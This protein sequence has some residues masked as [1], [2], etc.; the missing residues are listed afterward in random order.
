MNSTVWCTLTAPVQ[1]WWNII[2][3]VSVVNFHTS[4]AYVKMCANFPQKI[5]EKAEVCSFNYRSGEDPLFYMKRTA[6]LYCTLSYSWIA[7]YMLPLPIWMM[8]FQNMYKSSIEERRLK[9]QC[10]EIFWHFFISWIE[11]IW[12]PDKQAKMVLLKSSF[13]R[14]RTLRRLTLRGVENW[15]FRKSKIG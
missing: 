8:G 9:G 4:F 15:N 14:S 6:E 7:P 13:S 11:A 1:K 3:S 12:A 5:K 2:M 10:H